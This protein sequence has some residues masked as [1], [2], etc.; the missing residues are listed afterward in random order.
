MLKRIWVLIKIVFKIGALIFG[1]AIYSL[2]MV[3]L[4]NIYVIDDN[5]LFAI[6]KSVGSIPIWEIIKNYAQDMFFLGEHAES[7]IFPCIIMSIPLLKL[8]RVVLFSGLSNSFLYMFESLSVDYVYVD[9]GEYAFSLTDEGGILAGAFFIFIR[10]L[11]LAVIVNISPIL[12]VLSLPFNFI[13]LF[14]I[15]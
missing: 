5:R 2:W 6:L 11:A 4:Y 14:R 3:D 1:M 10:L 13:Q 15:K 9:S 7:M 12:L 8:I